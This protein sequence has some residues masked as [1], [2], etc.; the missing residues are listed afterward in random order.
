MKN[1]EMENEEM[2]NGG[3]RMNG[4][5]PVLRVKWTVN[6]NNVKQLASTHLILVFSIKRPL[7]TNCTTFSPYLK[8]RKKFFIFYTKASLLHLWQLPARAIISLI[9]KLS[10]NKIYDSQNRQSHPGLKSHNLDIGT[11]IT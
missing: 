8:H 5:L 3:W 2:K 10:Q 7:I 11:C 4:C 9:M 6:A 1:E